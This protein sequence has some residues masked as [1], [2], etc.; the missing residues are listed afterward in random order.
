MNPTPT[1]PNRW[2]RIT[3]FNLLFGLLFSCSALGQ[4]ASFKSTYKVID[5]QF[6]WE[7]A[8]ADAI[9]RGGHL[10]AI[11][12][13]EEQK[14]VVSLGISKDYWLGGTDS[15]IEGQW[16]WI[17]GEPFTYNNWRSGEPN[18][19]GI[20]NYL[21]MGGGSIDNQWNDSNGDALVGYILEIPDRRKPILATA[22]AQMVNGFVVGVTIVNR[23][24]GYID[25]PIITI[26]GGGGTGA[27]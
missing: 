20:E 16:E 8:Q 15:K 22:V 27:N 6:T 4:T 9:K 24:S 19:L 13:I 12:T 5:G 26:T 17:T 10:A 3:V 21:M 1:K 2:R 7:Q 23:G 11:R 25:N 14:E 18:N